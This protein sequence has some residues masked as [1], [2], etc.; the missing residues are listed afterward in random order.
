MMVAYPYPPWSPA[1]IV[2]HRPDVALLDTALEMP[3]KR[4][5]ELATEARRQVP[6]LRVLLLFGYSEEVF[7]APPVEG[8]PL[9]EKP[10]TSQ[11]LLA[12]VRACLD[13]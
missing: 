9:L 3:G 1:E 10:F 2:A 5:V 4:G 6:C 7:G 13:E 8:P 12:R 11:Q